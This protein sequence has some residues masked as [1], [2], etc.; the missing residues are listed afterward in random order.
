MS[1]LYSRFIFTPG[2]LCT[3]SLFLKNCRAGRAGRQRG[4]VRR[5]C[6][7]S[8]Y[9]P[10]DRPGRSNHRHQTRRPPTCTVGVPL[11][12]AACAIS[13]SCSIS[14]STKWT[15]SQQPA[16][17]SSGSRRAVVRRRPAT[18]HLWPATGGAACPHASDHHPIITEG[19]ITFPGYSSSTLDRMGFSVRQGPQVG[20][21]GREA[22]RQGGREAG[23]R[24]SRGP[25]Q[26]TPAFT[27]HGTAP[28]TRSLLLLPHLNPH[29]HTTHTNPAPLLPPPPPCHPPV[30][31][32]ASRRSDSWY[33]RRSANCPAWR[34]A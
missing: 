10:A 33:S 18:T 26:P 32:T 20:A 16:A 5:R 6:S 23:G 21:A 31:S 19:T 14:I 12:P 15:C 17:D 7:G 11:T 34:S 8:R 24:E 3:R 28:H 25:A 13:G 27:A 22:G 1:A 2:R 29:P 4:Q 30:Y 9:R